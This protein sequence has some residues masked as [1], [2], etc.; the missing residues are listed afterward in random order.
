MAYRSVANMRLCKQRPLLGNVLNNRRT[1]F[2]VVRL[3]NAMVICK[4]WRLAVAL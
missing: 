4:A 1:V 3:A 2:S